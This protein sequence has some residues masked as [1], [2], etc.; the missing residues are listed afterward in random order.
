MFGVS[1][2]VDI[3]NPTGQSSEQPILA[4]S[5]LSRHVRLDD[6]S[7]SFQQQLLVNLGIKRQ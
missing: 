4:D 6:S 5:A 1:I 3:L 7:D 2:L